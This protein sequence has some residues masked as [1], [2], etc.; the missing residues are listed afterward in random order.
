MVRRMEPLRVGE[1]GKLLISPH[2]DRLW[3]SSLFYCSGNAGYQEDL[4]LCLR[5]GEFLDKRI[6]GL[7][8]C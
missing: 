5:V 4:Q 1:G 2:S 3:I 6:G 7:V 8:D